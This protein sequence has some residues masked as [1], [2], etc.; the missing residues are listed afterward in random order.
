MREQMPLGLV[1]ELLL[2]GILFLQFV[3]ASDGRALVDLVNE[4]LHIGHLRPDLGAQEVWSGGA[5]TPNRHLHN[6]IDV[7]EHVLPPGQ[8]V[9]KDLPVPVRFEIVSIDRVFDL[10][11]GR[12]VEVE[13]LAGI[14]ANSA[15]D[16]EEP[17]Q[18]FASRFRRILRQEEL[19][20]LGE[21]KQDRARVEDGRFAVNDRWRLRVG[22]DLEEIWGV[23]LALA[24][25]DRNNLVFEASLFKE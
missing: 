19:R 13:G 21:I 17:R 5:P 3:N 9:V 22:I 18:E 6:R 23:L 16:E 7:A 4:S 2:E 20:L 25:V 24:R 8:P 1:V 10:L 11:G 12:D 14:R 15:R